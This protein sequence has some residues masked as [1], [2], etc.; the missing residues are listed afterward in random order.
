MHSI[1]EQLLQCRGRKNDAV[2]LRID[3]K[4]PDALKW[5]FS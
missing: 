2:N 1:V 4:D 3:E 5:N